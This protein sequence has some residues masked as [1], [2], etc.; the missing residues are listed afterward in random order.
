MNIGFVVVTELPGFQQI[1][2]QQSFFCGMRVPDFR[3]KG[4]SQQA[5]TKGYGGGGGSDNTDSWSTA[6]RLCVKLALI[7]NLLG[8]DGF[9]VWGLGS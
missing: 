3:D 7:L 8:Q 6:I 4:M 1:P 5:A 2:L 9:R